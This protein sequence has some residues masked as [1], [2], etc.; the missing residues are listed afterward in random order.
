MNA[1]LYAFLHPSH[2]ILCTA[3]R[4]CLLARYAQGAILH[5]VAPGLSHLDRP[6]P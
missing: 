4:L 2:Q 3:R 5:V 6:D 1:L